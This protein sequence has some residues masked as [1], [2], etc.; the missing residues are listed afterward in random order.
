M[1]FLAEGEI[2]RDIGEVAVLDEK[3]KRQIV[4]NV[5]GQ[6]HALQIGAPLLFALLVFGNV[7]DDGDA[8]T[9][10]QPAL[11]EADPAIGAVALDGVEAL[12]PMRGD[13]LRQPILAAQRA[14][15]PD[16]I[17]LA[18]A[19]VVHR[20]EEIAKPRARLQHFGGQRKEFEGLAAC[21]DQVIVLVVD[22]ESCGKAVAHHI[23][24]RRLQ[25]GL[26]GRPIDFDDVS[27]FS[28]L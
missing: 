9:T 27:A 18:N 17:L 3:R 5:L 14:A 2:D 24:K 10:R 4:E 19:G 21:E 6:L 26:G 13:F 15:L 1:I 23:E 25:I 7:G 11:D 22:D 12:T 20:T 8:V 28:K 16:I